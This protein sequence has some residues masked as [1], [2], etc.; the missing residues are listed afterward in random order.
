LWIA[1]LLPLVTISGLLLFDA[2]TF[3]VSGAFL[4]TLPRAPRA[5]PGGKDREGDKPGHEPFLQTAKAGIA[6]IW[7]HRYLRVIAV[8]CCAVVLFNGVDDVALV[9]LARDSLHAP[10]WGMSLLY[11]GV[12]AGLLAGFALLARFPRRIPVVALLMA[13]YFV[14][15]LGNLLT[16]TARAIAAAFGLQCVRGLGLSPMDTAHDTLIQRIVPA[17]LLGRVFANV[18]GAVSLAAGLS[19]LFGGLLLEATN[20]RVTLIVAGAGGIAVTPVV[21]RRLRAAAATAASPPGQ[22]GP[23]E[24]RT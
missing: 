23:A 24:P 6:Y 22:A 19:Y 4:L 10:S 9:Y 7:H 21:A 18:Y 16:G 14:S 2:A 1:A 15:G 11:A 5:A 17:P 20:P 8:G 3:A 13:G 12:G